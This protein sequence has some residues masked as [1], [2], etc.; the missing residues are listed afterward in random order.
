MAGWDFY[1]RWLLQELVDIGLKLRY[2]CDK[3]Q[4]EVMIDKGERV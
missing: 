1:A 3:L 2:D 4:R